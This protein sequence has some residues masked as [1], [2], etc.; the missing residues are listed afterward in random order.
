MYN[1]VKHKNIKFKSY[2]LDNSKA[3]IANIVKLINI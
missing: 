2:T 1:N 3:I